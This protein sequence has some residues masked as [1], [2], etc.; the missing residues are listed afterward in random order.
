MA[1]AGPSGQPPSSR[2]SLLGRWPNRSSTG[3]GS[4]ATPLRAARWR[5][6]AA[7]AGAP[8]EQQ[9]QTAAGEQ[10][11]SQR[12]QRAGRRRAPSACAPGGGRQV[13]VLKRLARGAPG[14]LFQGSRR[15]PFIVGAAARRKRQATGRLQAAISAARGAHRH[16]SCDGLSG[17]GSERQLMAPLVAGRVNESSCSG[18]APLREVGVPPCCARRPRQGAL[19]RAGRGSRCGGCG[20]ACLL[21]C[22]CD[23]PRRP[24][25]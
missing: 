14:V 11:L 25:M 15:T 19:L 10:R 22:G 18:S 21:A 23:A 9:R 5:H 4:K 20:E 3:G 8:P 12:R 2:T 13:P 24:H 1:A 6:A 17:S 16:G 7:A